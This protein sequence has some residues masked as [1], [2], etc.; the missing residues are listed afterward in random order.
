[1]ALMVWGPAALNLTA[2]D[3]GWTDSQQAE[4]I[5]HNPAHKMEQLQRKI[6]LA[7]ERRG[8][9][10]ACFEGKPPLCPAPGPGRQVQVKS[11]LNPPAES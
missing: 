2:P 10:F 3:I 6:F 5:G 11:Q 9:I 8:P 4:R 1:M 7:V